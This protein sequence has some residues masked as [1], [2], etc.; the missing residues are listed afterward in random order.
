MRKSASSAFAFDSPIEGEVAI[1][2]R[3]YF[4]VAVC[5]LCR[6]ACGEMR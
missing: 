4:V 2:G 3:L 1:T 5:V 6:V